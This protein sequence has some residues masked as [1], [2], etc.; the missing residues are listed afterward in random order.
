MVD[1]SITEEQQA[2]QSLAHQFAQ[3]EIRPIAPSLDRLSDPRE[4]FPHDMVKKALQL[5]FTS[6]LIPEEYGGG[7]KGDLEMALVM[8][9]IGWADAGVATTI[10]LCAGWPRCLQRASQEQKGKWLRDITSDKTGTY[11]VAIALTE[12]GSG[13]DAASEDPSAGVRTTAARDGDKYVLRGTKVFITNG[14]VAKL[15]LVFAK[16]DITKG[17]RE[18]LSAFLVPADAPGLSIGKI[19]D[20]MGQRLSQQA[21]IILDDVRVPRANMVG[22]EGEG[23]D[24]LMDFL[25]TGGTALVGGLSVGLARAAFEAATQY[26]KE[27]IQG[28]KRIIE[29]QAVGFMLVDMQ[30]KIEAT[31]ALLWRACWLNDHVQRDNARAAMV[32]VYSSE[33]ALDVATKAVQ[34][35]GGYG[36][37]KDYPLEKFMRDARILPIY[38]LTNQALRLFAMA[39]L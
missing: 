31:R 10:G 6:L 23:V 28:G 27:R 24:I 22:K 19:E 18:G 2:L 3:R 25:A 11:L 29:H 1:F 37:M 15:Y 32:K 13:S 36:Y 33:M 26:A 5:G 20:K 8:E 35:L 14:G 30:M 9:E 34:V 7:G 21:E 12:P 38:D 39:S 4:C 16:T 17:A